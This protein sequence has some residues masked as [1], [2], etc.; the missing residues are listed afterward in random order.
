MPHAQVYAACLFVGT[1]TNGHIIV[2]DGPDTIGINGG[3]GNDII[4]IN[5][6]VGVTKAHLQSADS[7]AIANSTTIDAG[8]GNNQVENS[9]SIGATAGAN[10]LPVEETA[11]QAAATAVGTH[12]GEGD[13]AIKNFS[14]IAATANATATT[15][16]FILAAGGNSSI[17]TGTSS[18]AS[19]TGISSG[20]GS[21]TIT[22]T[23]TITVTAEAEANVDGWKLQLLDYA[24]VGA[25]VTAEANA[26]GIFSA[27]AS[28]TTNSGTITTNARA[29]A[30]A[31]EVRIQAID[32]SV[33]NAASCTKA[34]AIGIKSDPSAIVIQNDGTIASTATAESDL[35]TVE[36]NLTDWGIGSSG[37]TV[38]SKATG[39]K[40]NDQSDQITNTGSIAATATSEADKVSIN[41]TF[42][43]LTAGPGFVDLL[44]ELL[45]N[46]V[47]SADTLSKATSAGISGEGGDDAISNT[48][49][50]NASA[51]A[52]LDGTAVS[53]GAEGI[54]KSIIDVLR[55]N[56]LA[57]SSP[58]AETFAVG[59]QGG[60]GKD[61]ITNQGQIKAE[62][63]STAQDISVNLSLPLLEKIMPFPSPSF[64][65]GGAGTT[66]LATATGIEGGK[67][68]DAI[69]HEGLIDVDAI[70]KTLGVTASVALQGV[71][72]AVKYIDAQA[73][74]ADASIKS[75]SVAIGIDGGEGNDTITVTNAGR[76]TSDA[77]ATADGITAAV[78]IQG[79]VEEALN[80]GASI[81][82]ADTQ[83]IATATGIEGGKGND[84]IDNAGT[85]TATAD[86]S[87]L[88][89]VVSVEA[90]L[91]VKKAVSVSAAITDT[92]TQ[93]WATAM[94]ISGSE[95]ND[96]IT[97][98]GSIITS[99]TPEASSTSVSVD[100]QNVEQGL[101]VGISYADAATTAIATAAGID[102]GSG[103]D[104]ITNTGVI[105]VTADPTSSS[106]SVSVTISASF[107]QE[108]TA[109]I[110]GAVTKGTT[111]AISNATGIS[112]GGDGDDT[113][114][115]SGTITVISNPDTNSASVSATLTGAQDGLTLG[116]AYA[117]TTTTAEAN[118]VGID[119]GSGNDTL[120]NTAQIEVTADPTSSSA[121]VSATITGST[122]GTGIVGGAA[123]TDGTTKAISNVAGIKG[124]EGNDTIT[125]SGRILVIS[126]PDADSASVSVTLG[127]AM[128]ELG[129]VGGFSYAD[130]TTTAEATVIG[131]DAGS[132]ND[133][134]TNNGV[135]EVTAEP[136]AS[137]ASIG[138][139]A[140][141]VKG[142]GAA[143][144]IS[145]TDGT[146]KA[147]ST[148]TGIAGGEGDDTIT[149][150]GRILVISN[151]DADSA[152]VS[153]SISAAKEGVAAGGTFA[154]ATTTA[155]A[156]ATGIDGGEG[157]D[158]INNA[159]TIEVTADSKSSSASVS[160]SAQGAMTGAALGVSLSDGTT[161]AISNAA[162]IKGG[163]GNDTIENSDRIA[164]TSTADIAGASVSVNLGGAQTGLVA[165]V[166]AAD[167]TASAE[168]AA[169][170]IS[171]GSGDDTVEN[172]GQMD[173]TATST[174]SSASVSVNAGVAVTGAAVGAALAD[175]KTVT[176]SSAVGLEGGM[177]NDTLTNRGFT[178]VKATS[179]VTAASVAVNLTGTKAGL[180]GGAS[181]VDGENRADAL[182]IGISGGGGDDTMS[183]YK[184]VQ[185]ESTT[186][187][188]RTNVS[189]TGSFSLY[190]A[191]AGASFADATNVAAADAR[192][193][194][195]GEGRDTITN[196]SMLGAVATTTAE[197]NSVALSVNV[198]VFGVGL[199][200]SLASAETTSSASATGIS[201]GA[202]D[203]KITN[204]SSGVITGT[205]N[206]TAKAKAISVDISYASFSTADATTTAT[207]G[208]AG[209]TGGSGQD[210]ILNEGIIN[211]NATSTGDGV[212]GTGSI[213]G[214]GAAK[215]DVNSSAITSGIDGGAGDDT[216]DNKNKITNTSTAT[217]RGRSVSVNLLGAVFAEAGTHAEAIT[218]GVSGGAG[219]DQVTN[220]GSIDLTATSNADLKAVS[221]TLIGYSNSDG[222]SLSEAIATGIYGGDGEN[223]LTNKSAGSIS[224]TATA[225]ADTA[226][227]SVNLAGAAK[228]DAGSTASAA[229]IGMAGGKE[230]DTIRNEGTITL[231]ATSDTDASATAVTLMG[232]GKSDAK[233]ISE[234]TIK[235][236]DGGDGVNTL[237]NIGSI[238]GSATAYADASSYD[239]QLVG[240]G[241][242]AAGTEAKAT[243]IGIAGGKD[244]ETIRNEG[245]INLTAQSTLVSASRSLKIFGVGFAD[246]DGV[247]LALSTGIDG[248]EGANTITNTSTGSIT[249]SSNA[250][251]T[252]TSMTAN[253]GVAGAKASTTSKAY[254]AGIMSGG[255]EDTII[256]EGILNVSATSSTYA[257]GGNLSLIGLSSGAALTEAIT[258]GIVA[259]DGKDEIINRGT[260]TVG[261]VQDNDH[262][263]AYS[264]VVSASISLFNISSATFGSKAQAT[265]ILGGGGDDAI[266]NTGTITVGDDDWMAKGRGYGFSGNFFEFFSLT[267]VG[268]TAETIAAGINGGDGND[269]LINDTGGLLTVKATSYAETEGAGDTTFGSP[270]SFASSTTK[271]TAT[272]MSGGEGDD[273]IEN[274]GAIDVYA[275]TLADAYTDA[276]AGWGSPL[277]DSHANATATAAGID[278]GK[279]Q[280]VVANS[281]LINVRALA[282]TSPYAK[283]DSNIGTNEAKAISYSKTTAFGIRAGDDGNIVNNTATGEITVTAIART[284]DAQGNVTKAESDE[285]A[286]ATAG[287]VTSPISANAVG[288]SLGNG[289]DTVTNDGR[290]TV[291]SLSDARGYANSS[292][293][294]NRAQ[295]DAT[296]YAAGTARGIAGGDGENKITNNGQV[297]V[298]ALGDASLV[299]RSWSRDRTAIANATA[300]SNAVATGIEADGNITNALQG[301]ITVTARTT[302]YA[303]ADTSAETTTA[304]ATLMSRATGINT[305]SDTIRMEPDRI[306]NDGTIKVKAL[307]GEDENG[308]PLSIIFAKSHLWVADSHA[309]ATGTSSVDAA[310]IRVGDRGAEIVN[311]GTMEVLARERAN[312]YAK[313]YSRD[314]NPDPSAT[315]TGNATAAGIKGG[316]GPYRIENVVGGKILVTA[317]ANAS[318]DSHGATDGPRYAWGTSTA[319]ASSTAYGI[320]IGDVGS[321]IR[322]QGVLT[323]GSKA[324]AST[325]SWADAG[326]SSNGTATSTSTATSTGFGIRTGSGDDSITNKKTISVTATANSYAYAYADADSWGEREISTTTA[327]SNA[328]AWGIHAGDGRNIIVNQG[329]TTVKSVTITTAISDTEDE[330]VDRTANVHNSLSAIGIQTGSG[331][332]VVSNFGTIT[333]TITNNGVSTLG[334]AIKTGAGNDTVVLGEVSTTT[335]E[336]DLGEGNDSLTFRGVPLVTGNITG[337]AGIDSLVFDGTGSIAFTPMAFENAIKQGAGTYTLANLP[338][339]Q[340]IEIKQG[341]LQVNNNYSMPNDSTFQTVVN[342]DGS[343]G[344]FKV[345]GT[346]GL[347]GDL[348]VLKGPGPFING[349]TYDII[350]A[351]TVNN[352]FGNVMLPNPNLFVSFGMNQFPTLV[353]IE[354]YVKNFSWL[355]TNRVEWTVANYLD[356]VLPSATG[357]LSWILGQVQNLSQSEYSTALSSL[358]SDSYDNFTRTTFSATHRYTKSLQYRMNNVRS[359][360]HAHQPGNQAPILLAYRDLDMSQLFSSH[361][362]SQIQGK[363]GL[364]FDDFGQWGDQ[365]SKEGYTGY[366]YFMR[367]ATLG[368]DYAL[369]DKIIAGVSLGYSRADIDLDHHRGSGYV[370][371]LYGSIYG[372]YF[373]KNLHIDGIISYG[374]NWYDNHRLITIGSLQRKVSSEHDGDLFSAFLG[375]GYTFDI[376]KWLI[377]P[378]ANLQYIYLD[379]A[380]FIEKGAGSLNLKV[381]GRKTDS[382]VSELGLRVARVFKTNCGS[383]IP[384]V[385]AAWLHDFDIDN[386]MINASFDGPPGASFSIKGQDVERNGAALGAGINFIHKS[387][388]STSLKYKGEFREKYKSNAIMG[389]IRFTF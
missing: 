45:G 156:I 83:A 295:S 324:S 345:N 67:G 138:V 261:A 267:S 37:L 55:G 337:G 223:T 249:V 119:G 316:D 370:K 369:T 215:V 201:G 221:V 277:A 132:G 73:S 254:S 115:N 102:G 97:N 380:S 257:V 322:N 58:K 354:T 157:N 336:I 315:S 282:E 253:I 381:N 99:A 123:L 175:G 131:I 108:W 38:M 81:A 196:T 231:N 113:V 11:S 296:A 278:A 9:G 266:L 46:S 153:V 260:I 69:S 66:A 64:A 286:T 126:N 117:D 310:G 146:T 248:G 343:F 170:G 243:A 183:N 86:A 34:E 317:D 15:N 172:L 200:A 265:G 112:G 52:T 76:I 179:E 107:S 110:G 330:V 60:D 327:Q 127:A 205:S 74:V 189:V 145:L 111:K 20:A 250:S 188:K 31:S 40:G 332:D 48:G 366:D 251:A 122:K 198:A 244:M 63:T 270:A 2:C 199:G 121:S 10:A 158:T 194:E 94:G 49:T 293:W 195:G 230:K 335:G 161:K 263:M 218:T 340:R 133:N 321:W 36:V 7:V 130:A 192:G 120:T 25:G 140:Q 56:S 176:T 349:T 307:A 341:I 139:T 308:N 297:I 320:N 264:N 355:V 12:T 232:Y 21:D 89:V 16:D 273:L 42:V 382:L 116:F 82:R 18:R 152:S 364:W 279:G 211:L 163:G 338:T 98:S 272:G 136:T 290:I 236:I 39:I 294:P 326:S 169:T 309:T 383:L 246:A 167:V 22:N 80:V 70:S 325:V 3:N 252:S 213:T 95:G 79:K 106:A 339:M 17:A 92:S 238:T 298:T 373:N 90:Q 210:L 347:A 255:G 300:N 289:D 4:T 27:G 103:N 216:I 68:D 182:A 57:S 43:D 292:S 5:T 61:S 13:D 41:F 220:D 75:E 285:N 77:T 59:I 212:A 357:D 109:A 19:A 359:Y 53:I 187:S 367:G 118:A 376:K 219:G 228:A 237:I 229:S 134:I 1:T 280:N 387:G 342:G 258:E 105:E 184:T 284:Y 386:L 181:L 208:S 301:V 378:F 368:F 26:V 274:K 288:I 135:I 24:K 312:L 101:A 88:S 268:A 299:T 281:G 224:A 85:I 275:H 147:I 185:A 241:T 389:E 371:S 385:S 302:T 319:A 374:K 124:G 178:V 331:N 162:G 361:G 269:T 155:Q 30:D 352:S 72:T 247:A 14:A 144:G 358:S 6:G 65:L 93:A 171:G 174:I 351:H 363:N 164:V 362:V 239:I 44:G 149:N 191:A 214:Y 35:W 344:K 323:V 259:G 47:G 225:N 204:I 180:A 166:A 377:E 151:P 32:R 226:S 217:A 256:N 193:I 173:V 333:T 235:G 154:D 51:T 375:A 346:T 311:R 206:A 137:S 62:A 329:T 388:L 245:A 276:F 222:S 283:A 313:A 141:F 203:D 353:Q 197:T 78:G 209:M 160:V 129:L 142:M 291:S 356:Q 227:V 262:P 91:S 234:A 8:S 23:G 207:A 271:A 50:I 348:N 318:S 96:S 168:S 143:V 233:A 328:S 150:S 287:S 128:G 365:G 350:E 33:A 100:F 372:S 304:T 159:G 87:A 165:G 104:S 303:D 125:N 71:F 28:N 306:L 202:G 242:A 240:G 314:Y 29:E 334:I 84:T 177:G 360:A 148:A 190:G 379:E 186:T 114:T 305:A 54:P 384:E